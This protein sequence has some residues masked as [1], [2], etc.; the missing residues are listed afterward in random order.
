MKIYSV[1]AFLEK[2]TKNI[3]VKNMFKKKVGNLIFE[4]TD[5]VSSWTELRNKV[6][7]LPKLCLQ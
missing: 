7:K 6:T 2:V 4:R 1:S 5:K 3:F